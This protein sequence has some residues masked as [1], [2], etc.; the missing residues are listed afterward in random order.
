MNPDP[1]IISSLSSGACKIVVDTPLAT[2]NANLPS[3]GTLDAPVQI[4]GNEFINGIWNTTF[5]TTLRAVNE[6][7]EHEGAFVR[8]RSFNF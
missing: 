5:A 2:C 1:T 4:V 6:P 3:T 8:V 7:N